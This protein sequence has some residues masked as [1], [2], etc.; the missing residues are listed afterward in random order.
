MKVIYLLALYLLLQGCSKS[1]SNPETSVNTSEYNSS[2]YSCNQ[3]QKINLNKLSPC[4]D[5]RG[6]NLKDLTISDADLKGADF[7]NAILENVKFNGVNMEGVKFY[8]ASLTNVEFSNTT[9]KKGVWV[10]TKIN[11]VN[12]NNSQAIASK[13]RDVEIQDSD[14]N[15]SNWQE[16]EVTDSKII[17]TKGEGIFNYSSWERVE[18]YSNSLVNSSFFKSKFY[19]VDFSSGAWTLLDKVQKG[20]T[21]SENFSENN[22]R[23]TDWR[24]SI[25]EEV[26]FT[27]ANLFNA[28]FQKTK[29]NRVNFQG[30]NLEQAAL[31]YAQIIDA[32]FSSF[33]VPSNNTSNSQLMIDYKGFKIVNKQTKMSYVDTSNSNVK[34]AYFNF[35]EMNSSTWVESKISFS[36]FSYTQFNDSVF[37]QSAIYQSLFYETEMRGSYFNNSNLGLEV[38]LSSLPAGKKT[39]DFINCDLQFSTFNGVN[40]YYFNDINSTAHGPSFLNSNLKGTVWDQAYNEGASFR[41][42]NLINS[43]LQASFLDNAIFNS[44]TQLPFSLQT[45]QNLG[46][47]YE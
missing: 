43:N 1:P 44:A 7:T 47:I 19:K 32:D 42:S 25:L 3:L 30:S 40:W 13:W 41:G 20:E 8:N 46:M 4:M 37:S 35:I 16:L 22:L 34:Y 23:Y 6:Q 9:I 21:I 36:E 31:I 18:F 33:V 26:S 17:N 11:K 5:F 10:R 39:I 2:T 45:A 38:F 27:F 28:Q 12:F 24:E 15:N 14:F 29:M